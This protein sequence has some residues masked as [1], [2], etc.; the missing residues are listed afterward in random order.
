MNK[1]LALLL[2]FSA[3]GMGS[4]SVVLM[5]TN[6]FA[7]E[8]KVEAPVDATAT[9]ASPL[10]AEAPVVVD[11][12]RAVEVAE[13]A[14]AD[15]A[16]KEQI[17][18]ITE[19]PQWLKNA[20]GFALKMPVIGPYVVMFLQWMGV[21]AA[22][23]TALAGLLLALMKLMEKLGKSVSALNKVKSLLDKLYPWVA[24]LSMLNVKESPV[25]KKKEE[26][27]E[28]TQTA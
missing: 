14:E 1:L 7:D 21:V 16:L 19:P 26:K 3:H 6:V 2:V 4:C 28:E 25:A 17:D 15:I 20:I 27:K 10:P 24:W 12:E 22:F 23:L 11:E 5:P 8:A 13:M 18:E 9:A